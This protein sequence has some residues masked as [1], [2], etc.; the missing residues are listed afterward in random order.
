MTLTG[1]TLSVAETVMVT[2]VM[3]VGAVAEHVSV[4]G[5]PSPVNIRPRSG[6]ISSMSGPLSSFH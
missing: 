2:I 5:T 4:V 1:I 6:A 3:Q